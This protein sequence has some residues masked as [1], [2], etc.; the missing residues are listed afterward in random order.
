MADAL[1]P[2]S[3]LTEQINLIAQQRNS[4][5]AAQAQFDIQN[6]I[7]EQTRRNL[8]NEFLATAD[9]SRDPAGSMRT[10][11][12]LLND[13]GM[14]KASMD[15]MLKQRAFEDQQKQLA[16][17]QRQQTEI[18][19][20]AAGFAQEGLDPTEQASLYAKQLS[21][22]G[23]VI[24]SQP[25]VG[26]L[27]RPELP[28]LPS[29][30]EGLT[31]EG[32]QAQ[33]LKLQGLQT[34]ID[35]RKQGILESRART[36]KLLAEAQNAGKSKPI[37]QTAKANFLRGISR[38]V[39]GNPTIKSYKEAARYVSLI[40]TVVDDVN[41]RIQSGDTSPNRIGTD[42]AVINLWN[43]VQEPG[44]VTRIEEFRTTKE[45]EPLVNRLNQLVQQ[46]KS[47]GAGVTIES[48]NEIRRL[49]NIIAKTLTDD[50]NLEVEGYRQILKEGIPDVDEKTFD[51]VARKFSEIDYTPG[52]GGV[53]QASGETSTTPM[54]ASQPAGESDP[55]TEWLK[56][57]KPHLFK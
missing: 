55:D 41:K 18:G 53:V 33:T 2:F 20:A 8:A 14:M 42:Q 24:Q 27:V 1:N 50:A 39:Q 12:A 31:P 29:G 45:G 38:D 30:A 23:V 5:Q 52:N 40:N 44:S 11:G 10:L 15:V 3:S 51:A 46:V 37:T 6:A 54:Q 57:N 21:L 16:E 26:Q 43:R 4:P 47:G 34:E 32:K 19:Q 56:R 25:G 22:P 13:T 9:F 17:L 48:I 35:D 36:A 7:A 28:S 49:A